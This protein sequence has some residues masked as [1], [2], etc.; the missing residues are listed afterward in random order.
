M[1]EKMQQSSTIQH[2]LKQN[3]IDCGKVQSSVHN[4]TRQ[5][6]TQN[7]YRRACSIRAPVELSAE[8]SSTH[9][10]STEH[11]TIQRRHQLEYTTEELK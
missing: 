3:G 8:Y 5:D 6:N 10:Y 1:Y 11:S 9:K 2:E 7:G 4:R